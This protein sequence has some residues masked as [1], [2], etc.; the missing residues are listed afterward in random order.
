MKEFYLVM[1]RYDMV[2]VT[3]A[4]DDETVARLAITIGSAG[5]I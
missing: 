3:E 1:G 4:P 5:A 2:V